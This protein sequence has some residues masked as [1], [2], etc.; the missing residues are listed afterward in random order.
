MLLNTEP[1][2]KSV[3]FV[4]IHVYLRKLFAVQLYKIVGFCSLIFNMLQASHNYPIELRVILL[5]T[6]PDSCR[7]Y[8]DFQKR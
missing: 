1:Y 7:I 8:D 3:L 5:L 4:L 6:W 2:A